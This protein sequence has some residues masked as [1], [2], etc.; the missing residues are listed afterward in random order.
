MEPPHF[1]S[2]KSRRSKPSPTGSAPVT[3]EQKREREG[4]RERERERAGG[5]RER[6]VKFPQTSM[7][8]SSR[9]G[10]QQKKEIGMKIEEMLLILQETSL[11]GVIASLPA[12]KER[13][14]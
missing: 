8:S 12:F 1:F 11:C 14:Q 2:L 10:E 4:K 9:E 6:K 5:G 13:L 7:W 3:E